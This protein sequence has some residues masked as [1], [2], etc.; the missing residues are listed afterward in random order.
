[1]LIDL[2]GGEVLRDNPGG[3]G[4]EDRLSKE[5][6]RLHI[7]E[8]TGWEIP[9][10]RTLNDVNNASAILHRWHPE[11]EHIHNIVRICASEVHTRNASVLH[12]MLQTCVLKLVLVEAYAN[13]AQDDGLH[14]AVASLK[15]AGRF[16]HEG[17][18]LVSWD[19][20]H[21]KCAHLE[22]AVHGDEQYDFMCQFAKQQIS[23][24]PRTISLWKTRNAIA[25]IPQLQLFRAGMPQRYHIDVHAHTRPDLTR[26]LDAGSIQKVTVLKGKLHPLSHFQEMSSSLPL[27]DIV[28][29]LQGVR[30]MYT[31]V[32]KHIDDNRAEDLRMKFAT[33]A[34]V[35]YVVLLDTSMHLL[36]RIPERAFI[37][38]CTVTTHDDGT[39]TISP[40]GFHKELLPAVARTAFLV[41]EAMFDSMSRGT[42]RYESHMK[43]TYPYSAIQYARPCNRNE[44]GKWMFMDICLLPYWRTRPQQSAAKMQFDTNMYCLVLVDLYSGYTIAQPFAHAGA[45]NADLIADAF[46]QAPYNAIRR[47]HKWRLTRGHVHTHVKVPDNHDEV[48]RRIF[49]RN[50]G[51]IRDR[52]RAFALA[53]D[54]P[55]HFPSKAGL[56]TV[57]SQLHKIPPAYLQQLGA[58]ACPAW[59]PQEAPVPQKLERTYRVTRSQ[60]AR[61]INPKD[62]IDGL[63]RLINDSWHDEELI[64]DLRSGVSANCAQVFQKGITSTMIR[65]IVNTAAGSDIKSSAVIDYLGGDLV[66]AMVRPYVKASTVWSNEAGKVFDKILR[67]WLQQSNEDGSATELKEVVTDEEQFWPGTLIFMDNQMT[68][69]QVK[70]IH[71]RCFECYGVLF[72]QMNKQECNHLSTS[73]VES[74]IK[75]LKENVYTFFHSK[76]LYDKS[77][78]TPFSERTVPHPSECFWTATDLQRIVDTLN[79][80]PSTSRGRCP[81]ELW[82]TEN[83]HTKLLPRHKVDQHVY[84]EVGP[85]ILGN[86]VGVLSTSHIGY[87]NI[88]EYVK[89][90]RVL[91]IT[92]SGVILQPLPCGKCPPNNCKHT[93]PAFVTDSN[94]VISAHTYPIWML[95]DYTRPSAE[96]YTLSKTKTTRD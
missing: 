18:D 74:K 44:C 6:N 16:T 30:G 77:S 34:C 71:K 53:D 95:Q 64:T 63:A 90:A 68:H 38:H 28:R 31:I 58:S 21:S 24:P 29:F 32:K 37:R 60:T 40:K 39:I 81:N 49:R 62:E 52:L 79:N 94:A 61:G 3:K 73:M 85:H 56:S 50:M 47:V 17:D 19:V 91:D 82:C 12:R 33:K 2:Q 93:V 57:T 23:N 5:I 67:E 70:K 4:P 36:L 11:D 54:L 45:S 41:T 69:S 48:P 35:P 84:R 89:R 25:R 26:S 59:A 65:D 9:S 7:K 83:F 87:K 86:D 27:V 13:L 20:I 88:T 75:Q 15:D 42:A 22:K 55:R 43:H 78:T 1:M 14:A 10:E 76:I 80:T 46:S 51:D 92:H 96:S 72:G 66:R 8:C